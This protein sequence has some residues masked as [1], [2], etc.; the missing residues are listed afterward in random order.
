MT[1][2]LFIDRAHSKSIQLSQAG[3]CRNL[4]QQEPQTSLPC[5]R[6]SPRSVQRTPRSPSPDHDRDA[7]A[8]LV[9]VLAR[10][11]VLSHPLPPHHCRPL[12]VGSV[13]SLDGL[14]VGNSALG[15]PL[16]LL[17]GEEAVDPEADEGDG[18]DTDNAEDDHDAGLLGGPVAPNEL[19]SGRH[20]D[21][22]MRG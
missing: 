16:S 3:H 4:T 2:W 21:D 18:D 15:F 5:W 12:Y 17:G 6:E 9:V 1:A 11:S 10:S 8:H 19:H 20:F 13:C 22:F 14:D 7:S